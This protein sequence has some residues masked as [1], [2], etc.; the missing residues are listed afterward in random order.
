MLNFSDSPAH[1]SGNH[2]VLIGHIYIFIIFTI[3]KRSLCV[4]T[5]CTLIFPVF[6]N[7]I[8]SSQR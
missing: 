4:L 7:L 1:T 2:V 3:S 8:R 6:K 5:H